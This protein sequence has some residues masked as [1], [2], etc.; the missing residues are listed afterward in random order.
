MAERPRRGATDSG[1]R[2][3]Q[4]G[5]DEV[6]VGGISDLAQ[7]S[8]RP[9]THERL[10]VMRRHFSQTR[11]SLPGAELREGRRG[12]RAGM[13]VGGLK[14]WEQWGDRLH[15]PQLSNELRRC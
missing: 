14:K 12:S 7:R 8:N 10:L 2:V 3:T 13:R 4:E 1:G 6:D 15:D 9:G 11:E 5:K